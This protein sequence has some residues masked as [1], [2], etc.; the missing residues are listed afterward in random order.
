MSV[1]QIKF[2]PSHSVEF[3]NVGYAPRMYELTSIA[4]QI[5]TLGIIL[6]MQC[7]TNDAHVMLNY[8]FKFRRNGSFGERVGDVGQYQQ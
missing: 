7:E 1:R 6:N 8:L 3:S 4:H 5:S 2:S